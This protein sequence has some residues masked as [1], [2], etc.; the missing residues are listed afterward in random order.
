MQRTDE[1][2]LSPMFHNWL[3]EQKY[4]AR[5][6][7]IYIYIDQ[8]RANIVSKFANRQKFKAMIK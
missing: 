2:I 1:A 4:K 8:N 3:F 5:T 6:I 7:Y